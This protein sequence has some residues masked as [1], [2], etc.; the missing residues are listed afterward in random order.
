LRQQRQH[1]LQP[2]WAPAGV[3]ASR[4]TTVVATGI[5]R[6]SSLLLYRK[7]SRW[8]LLAGEARKI[9]VPRYR[10]ISAVG[11]R[12]T[13]VTRRERRQRASAAASSVLTRGLRR[14]SETPASASASTSTS[15]AE[16]VASRMGCRG[17]ASCSA[18]VKSNPTEV[19]EAWLTT[20]S[21]QKCFGYRESR[22]VCNDAIGKS[23]RRVS[24]AKPARCYN[25]PG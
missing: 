18:R 8:S 9:A 22:Y 12:V 7:Y 21:L 17:A 20:F 4:S 13:S 6:T 1:R 5:C 23:R 3:G 24:A 25:D 14:S 10:S 2:H 19:C 15:I 11:T 16:E